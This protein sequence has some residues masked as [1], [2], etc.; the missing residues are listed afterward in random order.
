MSSQKARAIEMVWRRRDPETLNN[1]RKQGHAQRRRE[2]R[3]RCFAV[4]ECSHPVTLRRTVNPQLYAAAQSVSQARGQL[5]CCQQVCLVAQRGDPRQLLGLYGGAPRMAPY[6]MDRLL[7][8]MRAQVAATFSAFRPSLPLT[9]A[10]A[11]LCYDTLEEVRATPC[12]A[13]AQEE[14]LLKSGL[15]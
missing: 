5:C 14:G 12:A 4:A 2:G 8:R 6:M 15:H 13:F 1:S 3:C 10:A 11:Q 9:F 7:E